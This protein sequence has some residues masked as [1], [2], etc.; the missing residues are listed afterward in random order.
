MR[1]CRMVCTALTGTVA[2]VRRYKRPAACANYRLAMT[3]AL[4]NGHAPGLD[5][6]LALEPRQQRRGRLIER[7]PHIAIT[8]LAD[9]PVH[10]DRGAGLP[11]PR[12]QPKIRRDIARAL[13]PRGID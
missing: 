5:L 10:V 2:P 4:G 6:V 13:E 11:A 1:L 9:P 3:G 8:R 12:R 7:A